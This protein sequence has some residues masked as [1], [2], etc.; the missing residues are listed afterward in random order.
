M[1]AGKAGSSMGH[2]VASLLARD[3]VV[4]ASDPVLTVKS[5]RHLFVLP[6]V[7]GDELLPDALAQLALLKT[8]SPEADLLYGD[9]AEYF[10]GDRNLTP[11]FKPDWSPEFLV[12]NDYIGRAALRVDLFNEARLASRYDALDLWA[13]WLAQ[14]RR[15]GMSVT[16]VERVIMAIAPLPEGKFEDLVSRGAAIVDAHLTEMRVT[17]KAVLADWAHRLRSL[18]YDIDFPDDGPKVS[19]IIPTKNNYDVVKR[20]VESLKKT[21]YRN[22]EVVIIDNA[23]DEPR[24]VEYMRTVDAKVVSIKSPPSGFSYSYINNAAVEY[25]D[26]EYLVFL[27]DDTEVIGPK[28]L[29]KMVGWAAIPGVASVGAR[30]YFPNNLVQ[31]NGLINNL[32][33]G[34]LPAPAFK[35]SR[36]TSIGVRGQDRVVRNYSAVTAACMLTPRTSFVEDGGFNDT[37]FS[38]A[39]NDCDYGFRLTQRGLRHVCVPT[40]ELYHYEGATR[41]RGRG[42]D[43]ISEETAFIRRYGNW[44]DPYYNRNLSQESFVF[45]PA[46]RVAVE[47]GLPVDKLSVAL[48]THNLNFEGAPLVLLDIGRGLRQF[49]NGQVT[50]I[51]LIDGPLRAMYEA[52]GC[53]VIVRP[54]VGVFGTKSAIEL[55]Q[56]LQTIVDEL[57][58]AAAD[59]VIA[60]TVVCHWGMEAA[61]LARLPSLWI[62]HESEPPFSHLVDHGVHHVEVA[63]RALDEAYLNIFVA[64]ATRNL[65]RP[66]ANLNNLAVVYNGFDGFVAA[67]EMANTDRAEIR[68]TLDVGPSDLLFILPGTVCERKAQQ[69]LVHA[70]AALPDGVMS[71]CHFAIVGD[72]SGAYSRVLHHIANELPD[73]KRSRL[74]IIGETPHIWRY[75]A[76]ADAMV[77]TSHMESF[78]RVI[79]EAMFCGM[80]IISTPV[81]GISEQ[82]RDGQS[83]LLYPPGDIEKLCDAIKQ[84]VTDPALREK[85]GST[86]KIA[87]DRFPTMEEMQRKYASLVREAFL[88]STDHKSVEYGAS[89]L[90]DT[91]HD[92]SVWWNVVK[93]RTIASR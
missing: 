82:L 52:A 33:D 81:F 51:S 12:A 32:L 75:Y 46:R 30:L 53:T 15:T 23:S 14:S 59:V 49:G 7:P 24:T 43:K 45:E 60:N 58:G 76:A 42:N 65:Y 19:I 10:G 85:L 44:E 92:G 64:E 34:M 54:D 8:Q 74:S 71:R 4:Q 78:P 62:I 90:T 5:E 21:S 77:F 9:H 1:P 38:V 50:V 87:L 89:W 11:F 67:T 80:A 56:V 91:T 17:G 37:E 73:N 20:C 16:R 31:H 47:K 27:N 57:H 40:A 22:F 61:R 25:T 28:W 39:Y 70:I 55:E 6:L 3:K 72:R 84:L 2:D 86:A 36:R 79:Q 88:S 69:D 13:L 29:S 26:G 63:R 41:G 93:N 68:E 35:M 83:G 66:L 18:A 48:I